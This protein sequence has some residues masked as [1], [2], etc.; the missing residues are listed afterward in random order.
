MSTGVCHGTEA[1]VQREGQIRWDEIGNEVVL[2]K[3]STSELVIMNRSTRVFEDSA[4][5]FSKA[6]DSGSFVINTD[7]EV[8]G[9]IYAELAGYV[10]PGE[11]GKALYQR[12]T[13]DV[14][15]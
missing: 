14:Y 11:R 8:A 1:E 13:S 5:S 6:G 3:E 12:R 4:E 9:L 10:G 2:G 15:G 7:G